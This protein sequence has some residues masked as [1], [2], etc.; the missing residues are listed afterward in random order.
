MFHFTI[1][2]EV[3]PGSTVSL[4]PLAQSELLGMHVLVVDDNVTN[5][6]ILDNLLRNWGMVPT[7][8]HSAPAALEAMARALNEGVPFK[9]ALLDHQMPDMDGLQLTEQIRRQPELGTP[10]IMMLSSNGQTREKARCRDLGVASYLTKPVRQS[11]LLN[12]M[13]EAIAAHCSLVSKD[14][15]VSD[16]P[17]ASGRTLRI[18]IADD[19][20]VNRRV[21]SAILKKRGHELITV[22]N[23]AEAVAAIR[24]GAFDVVLMDVQMPEMDGLEATALVRSDERNTGR[25]IPIIALTAH[26]MKGDREACITAGMDG[27]ISKPVNPAE[28]MAMIEHVLPFDKPDVHAAA[29][30]APSFDHMSALDRLEGDAALLCELADMFLGQ[31]QRMLRDVREAVAAGSSLAVKQAAHAL[32]GSAASIGGVAVADAALQLERLATEP[33]MDGAELLLAALQFEL[34]RLEQDLRVLTQPLAA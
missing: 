3:N 9:L 1:P 26:A 13:L 22:E 29:P 2:F 16:A 34:S 31:S 27:Y 32:K 12:S 19:N 28:L 24:R 33:R 10:L 14:H 5:R 7:V 6:R 11:T 8:V 17:A 15:Y 23:G 30:L 21:A 25:H 4:T 18:L 20:E